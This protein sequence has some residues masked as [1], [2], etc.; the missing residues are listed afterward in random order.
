MKKLIFTRNPL[1]CDVYGQP[2]FL[3][4]QRKGLYEAQN[5]QLLQGALLD[6]YTVRVAQPS[7][8]GLGSRW[9]ALQPVRK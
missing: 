6:G 4:N 7:R 1:S 2:C 8:I 9:S 3:V 5:N